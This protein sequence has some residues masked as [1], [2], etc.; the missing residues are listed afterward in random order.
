VEYFKI[1]LPS[2][3]QFKGEWFY[4][5]NVAT[6]VSLFT[7]RESMSSNEWQRDREACLKAEVGNL[8]TAVKTL[9]QWGLSGTRLVRTFMHRWIQPLMSCRKPRHQYSGV[10]DSDRYSFMSLALS[11]IEARVRVVKTLSLE[12]FMDEDLPLPCPKTS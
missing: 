7:D 4:V 10:N 8:L 12:S 1:P 11:E 9:K 5:R 3:V 6:S 2:S